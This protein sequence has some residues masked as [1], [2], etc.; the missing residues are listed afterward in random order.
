LVNSAE[1]TP[2]GGDQ[3]NPLRGIYRQAGYRWIIVLAA[4][5]FLLWLGL[6]AGKVRTAGG[7]KRPWAVT[8]SRIMA[9][10][11]GLFLVRLF[12]FSYEERVPVLLVNLRGDRGDTELADSA[13]K[14]I[15]KLREQG[16]EIVPL[17]D[18]VS[19]IAER[20][21]V[22]KRCLALVIETAGLEEARTLVTRV[23]GLKVMML[24]PPQAAA[25]TGGESADSGLPPNVEV[26]VTFAN[27]PESDDERDLEQALKAFALR[28][29]KNLGRD[30]VCARIRGT[31]GVDLRRVLKTTGYSCF[32]DG[33]GY[34]RFGDEP[35]LV[36]ILDITPILRLRRMRDL[37]V[38]LS[39]GMF[40][41]GYFWWP[42]AALAKVLG[43][44]PNWA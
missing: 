6:F 44:S 9:A 32:L 13:F 2:A 40:R 21:Y 18:V 24:L 42:V 7:V 19:F 25:M 27:P 36:R 43:G 1:P 23:G 35:H 16:S 8:A 30:P 14:W 15:C 41:G 5:V 10:A 3:Q 11:G 17:V 34:N 31:S 22:P 37:N 33:S 28:A 39:V 38:A 26:G 29:S 12:L 4:L 20:R